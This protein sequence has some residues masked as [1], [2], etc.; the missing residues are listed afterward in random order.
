MLLALQPVLLSLSTGRGR[1]GKGAGVEHLPV[2]T[3]QSMQEDMC[4]WGEAER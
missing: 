2:K 4:E 3:M 1:G